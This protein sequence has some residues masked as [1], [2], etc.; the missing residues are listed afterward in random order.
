MPKSYDTLTKAI[1]DCDRRPGRIVIYN[2]DL[3]IYYI[4]NDFC[5]ISTK[6]K[7]V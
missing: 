3:K 1:W 2:E 4:K 5:S 6:E 7:I